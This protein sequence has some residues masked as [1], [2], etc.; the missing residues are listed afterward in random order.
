MPVCL[1]SSFT[2]ISEKVLLFYINR[3]KI[4]TE[5]KEKKISSYEITVSSYEIKISSYEIYVSSRETKISSRETKISWDEKI[6]SNREIF[7]ETNV[8]VRRLLSLYIIF[9]YIGYKIVMMV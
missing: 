5:I 1:H 7:F 2:F 8:G 4:S 6:V 3:R 9:T